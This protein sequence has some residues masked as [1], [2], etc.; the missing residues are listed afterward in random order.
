MAN[1]FTEGVQYCQLLGKC[2]QKLHLDINSHLFKWLL[3]RHEVTNTGEDVEK[4]RPLCTVG[5]N[6]N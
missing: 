2:K 3:Q 1:T 6:V 5:E 4:R